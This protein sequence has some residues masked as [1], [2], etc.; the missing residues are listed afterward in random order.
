[1]L[2][3]MVRPRRRLGSRLVDADASLGHCERFDPRHIEEGWH[4][5]VVTGRGLKRAG[6]LHRQSDPPFLA[7]MAADN[8]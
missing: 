3:C 6:P 4:W 1:M 8:H 7:L 5:R 2:R